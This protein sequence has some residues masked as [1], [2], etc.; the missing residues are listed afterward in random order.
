MENKK[1]QKLLRRLGALA[2]AVVMVMSLLPTSALQVS[3]EPTG[4]WTDDGNYTAEALSGEGTEGEPYLITSAAD[5]AKLAKDATLATGG[6]HFKITATKIVLSAHE[7]APIATFTGH[8]DGNGC[9]IIGMTQGTVTKNIDMGSWGFI[10]TLSASS[11]VKNLSLQVNIDI[12]TSKGTFALGGLVATMNGTVDNCVVSGSVKLSAGATNAYVGG[13]AGQPAGT[14]KNCV[15]AAAISV[16]TDPG[17]VKANMGVGGIAGFPNNAAVVIENCC[18]VG[19]VSLSG[20]YTGRLYGGGIVG[21]SGTY[22]SVANCYNAGILTGANNNS[23]HIA[24]GAYT[25]GY[26]ISGGSAYAAN[27]NSSVADLKAT[28][29]ANVAT[30]TGAN[31]WAE[32]SNGILLPLSSV[33]IPAP[34]PVLTLGGKAAYGQTVSA[35]VM[36]GGEGLVYQ[37]HHAAATDGDPDVA[38]SGATSAT[39]AVQA[40]DVGKTLVCT[41]TGGN[42][43]GTLREIAG[44]VAKAEG[45][46]APAVTAKDASGESAADGK[47]TGTSAAMEYSKSYNF[48]NPVDCT[49]TEIT[50]L[51]PGVY[52]VRVKATATHEAG[53]AAEITV[54]PW[55]EK[56]TAEGNYTTGN[57]SGT[58]KEND[59]YQITSAAD[60]AKLAKDAT[61]ATG[62]HHFKIT[63]P[64]IDL[65]TYEWVPITNFK[66]VLDG[67]G[68]KITGLNI[69][70]PEAP[71]EY[72][73]AGLIGTILQDSTVKGI[74]AEVAIY[75][76]YGTAGTVVVGGIAGFSRGI[77]DSC[78]I[79]GVIKLT[80]NG[81]DIKLDAYAGGIVGRARPQAA[82]DKVVISNCVN[83]ADVTVTN[84][85]LFEGNS[86]YERAGGIVGYMHSTIEAGAIMLNCVNTGNIAALGEVTNRSAAG[87][88]GY[89][90][91][92]AKPTHAFT[93]HNCYSTGKIESKTVGNVCAAIGTANMG[94]VYY[95]KESDTK[96]STADTAYCEEV[97]LADIKNAAFVQKLDIQACTINERLGETLAQKWALNA[98]NLPVPNGVL[99]TDKALTVNLNSNRYGS[100]KVEVQAPGE[101]TW[102]P[103]EMSC[104]LADGSMVKLTFTPRTGCLL[105]TVTIGGQEVTVT[106]GVHE[107]IANKS[108]EVQVNFKAG[109][110]K[111]MDP[112]YVNPNATTSGNGK[113]PATAY[114]TLTEALND[115]TN[116]L[117]AQINSN[118]TVY[119][120]GG[121]YEL[122]STIVLG[123]DQT[124][125]GR[126]TFKNYNDETPVITSAKEITG[127]FTKVAG[128]NYYSYQLPAS[129]KVGDAWPEFRDLLVNGERATLARTKD[130]IFTKSYKNEVITGSKVTDADNTVYIDPTAAAEITNANL[131]GVEVVS[132][133]EWKSQL[134]QIIGIRHAEGQLT[135]IDLNE[136][137]FAALMNYDATKKSLGGR[138]YWL[139]NHL[140]FLDEPGE[141]WYDSKTGTIYYCPY[142][143]Q[144]MSK[145]TVEYATLDKLIDIQSGANFTFDGISFTGT[146][147]NFINEHGLVAELGATYYTYVGDPGTNVP[148]A[149]IWADGSEGL[150]ILNCN[151]HDLAGHGFLS[152]YGTKDLT[153]TGNVFRNLG[154][155]GIIV[156]VNQRQWNEAGLLGASENVTI[157]NNYVTNIGIDVPC[158]PAIKVARS[159]NLKINH[160]TIIHASYSAIMAGWGWNV[161][162]SSATHNT[163]LINAEIAYNY[164]EDFLYGINDGGAIYTCGANGFTSDTDYI[165]TVHHNYIRGGA[166]SKTNIGIYHDGSCSNFHTYNNFIDDIKSTH[167]PIFFQDHVESQYSHNILAEKNF[168]TVSPIT[169]SAKADRNIV[170]K[171]NVVF[172]DRGAISA[173]A[174]AVMDNAGLEA[175]YKHIA[176]PMDSELRIADNSIRYS[177]IQNQE[178]KTESHVKITN[179]SDVTKSFTLSLM[180]VLPDNFTCT[181][182]GNG[183]E[184]DP[185]ESAIITI[186]F[187]AIKEEDVVDTGDSVIGFLITDST[188]RSVK[189]PRAFTF[190]A[191]QE[192]GAFE[193]E[194][195]SKI[196]A[197]GT[198]VLDGI[199]DEAYK[200]SYRMNFGTVFYPSNNALSDVTG[201]AYLLWDEQYL[202]LYAYVE[203]STV[204]SVG[205]EVMDDGNVNVMWATDA[206]EAYIY[207]NLRSDKS[208]PTLTKFAVDAFGLTRF[209]NLVPGIEYHNTLPYFTAFMNDGKIISDYKITNPTAGQMAATVEQPVDGY[210]IE[211]VLPLTE[212]S[213]IENKT[214]KEGDQIKFYIQNN[215]L[216]PAITGAGT[217]IAAKK[218]LET[219]FTLVKNTVVKPGDPIPPTGDAAPIA[220]LLTTSAVSMLA[221][222]VLLRKKRF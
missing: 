78:T 40:S 98:E 189:Y 132:L 184:L 63:A 192:G 135:E 46:V 180:D 101:N 67:N 22:A 51:V 153:I 50:G 48:Q 154:M 57:L 152:N 39:Y 157:T 111:D 73:A 146:T 30:M 183:V 15:N 170:L 121:R 182:S 188:G 213:H 193:M 112:I 88:A 186:T 99:A 102:V 197:Y 127:T 66:G 23:V 10:R 159:K 96:A 161:N 123:E 136:D 173:E 218:N 144:D 215:D 206:L 89:F 168:T 179:N 68:V 202:Y 150:K 77:V 151:F 16:T 35:S 203:D 204:M 207:T 64:T 163:N 17:T 65:S 194:D 108:A 138:A 33:S 143:D 172:A 129:T 205:K 32:D 201:Y 11:S 209:G 93:M 18:N 72:A 31:T 53:A 106:G 165:N 59:P 162:A 210:V 148:T 216:Q 116:L 9:Q 120:M 82:T 49:G 221:V 90:G 76:R 14:I 55:K 36:Y 91:N 158:A 52:Y 208:G 12:T 114:K 58:G 181:F 160:N 139:Q 198:P 43:S 74:S 176:E 27:D 126:V 195:G 6:H 220:M 92:E 110:S 113:T 141:F 107:F 71:A 128:K 28:L 56:W 86:R 119:L 94:S 5:L 211:M 7:W 25:N 3:A 69:G 85:N 34:E 8:L 171:D 97:T 149:A 70:T 41:V 155:S 20:G 38:I 187:T 109:P 4:K 134:F 174:K 178:G 1:T 199:L 84:D 200:N 61:L 104:L 105:D 214:P 145:A 137:Q 196:L 83:H 212:D 140:S 156:G 167:G 54:G 117:S 79:S 130:Y 177:Y 118:V 190:T 217:M 131:N 75:I 26:Y 81:K 13:I 115:L 2:L 191:E 45:P 87:I 44:V 125:L 124:S 185:G 142:T 60:L 29:N 24:T 169:T 95:A 164:I 175:A 37:W 122:D 21:R 133:V 219:T 42:I 100:V 166:H 80:A 62:G 147:A 47:I 19:N 103:A 222:V